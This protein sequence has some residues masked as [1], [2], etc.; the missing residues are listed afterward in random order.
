MTLGLY[1]LRAQT[2]THHAK[3]AQVI[4][5]TDEASRIVLD[6]RYDGSLLLSETWKGDISGRVNYDY[7]DDLILKSINING[8]ASVGCV[9]RT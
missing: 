5:V 1:T 9:P 2:Y 3:S 4:R 8:L 7:N 6:Y